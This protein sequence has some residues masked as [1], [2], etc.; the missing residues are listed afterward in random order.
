RRVDDPVS[1]G[2]LERVALE[3]PLVDSVEEGLLLRPILQAFGG[4][5]D[6]DIVA[7]QRPKEV[8]TVESVAGKRVEH[9]LD[10][11]GDDVAPGEVG[12]VKHGAEKTLS[13]QVLNKHLLHCSGVD[14]RVERC[15]A[16]HPKA[17]ECPLERLVVRVL[18]LDQPLEALSKLGDALLEL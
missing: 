14:L 16:E 12:V 2:L 8:G 15:L 7:V 6:S 11:A 4:T 13:E 10:V 3:E 18:A 9:P 5:L 1:V 17:S